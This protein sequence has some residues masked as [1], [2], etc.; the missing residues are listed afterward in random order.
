MKILLIGKN[1]QVGHALNSVLS[2]Y[3]NVYST[4]RSICD[5]TDLNSLK[6]LLQDYKPNIIINCAAYT[7]V[8][9]AESEKKIAKLVNETAPSLIAHEAN[10]IGSTFVH[11]STDYV[12]DGTKREAYLEEDRPNPLNFYGSSKLLGEIAIAD[13]CKK[14]LIF[15]TSWVVGSHGNNF[16]KKILDLSLKNDKLKIVNDQ[17]GAPTSARLIADVVGVIINQYLKKND[18][19]QYGL[20]H[21]T[22][23]GV[24]NWYEYACYVIKKAQSIK[25]KFNYDINKIESLSSSEYLAPAKRPLNSLLDTSKIKKTFNVQIPHWQKGVDEIIKEI[26]EKK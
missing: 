13:Q 19:F 25:K 5:L 9:K 24:T 12:F 22:A 2:K 8:D 15:R 18:N 10:K 23:S 6:N 17:Y 1:G 20:Y 26:Y 16:I 4:D 11:F 21:L 3:E 7:S 14:Y